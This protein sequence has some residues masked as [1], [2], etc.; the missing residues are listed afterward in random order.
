MREHDRV[1]STNDAANCF[2]PQ[3]QR[4]HTGGYARKNIFSLC[5]RQQ[6]VRQL[7][8]LLLGRKRDCLSR[9]G[10]RLQS[11]QRTLLANTRKAENTAQSSAVK[12]Q[13][14]CREHKLPVPHHGG[15]DTIETQ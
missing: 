7:P 6:G 3:Q 8:A 15:T 12:T 14:S 9:P 10:R 2:E 5:W 13:L 1:E 11:Q 4:Y